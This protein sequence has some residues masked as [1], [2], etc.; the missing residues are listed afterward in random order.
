MI[1]TCFIRK[2][3]RA[4]TRGV[5]G[6]IPVKQYK[7][8]SLVCQVRLTVPLRFRLPIKETTCFFLR[9]RVLLVFSTPFKEEMKQ[10]DIVAF[11]SDEEIIIHRFV[12]I[13][14]TKKTFITRPDAGRALGR[15]SLRRVEIVGKAIDFLR[16]RR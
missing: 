9:G 6:S 16:G 1:K 10:G 15:V 14:G 2:E 7:G 11:R 13:S 8:I 4:S 3:S 12:E 5:Q